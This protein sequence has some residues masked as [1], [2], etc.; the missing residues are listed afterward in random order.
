MAHAG[1]TGL[2]DSYR[3]LVHRLRVL[4]RLER[5]VARLLCLLGSGTLLLLVLLLGRLHVYV[6]VI[7]PVGDLVII[8]VG[9][10]ALTVCGAVVRGSGGGCGRGWLGG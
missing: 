10:V 1:G 4:F 8:R 2:T 7:H 9:A 3:V 5:D 6:V